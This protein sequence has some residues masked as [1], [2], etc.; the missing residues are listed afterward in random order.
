M[1]TILRRLLTAVAALA[2]ALGGV[3]AWAPPA[4]AQDSSAVAVNTRD[5]SSL[6]RF[7]FDIRRVMNG[8]IDQTN[9]AIAYASCTECQ[10]VAVSYQVVLVGHDADDVQ[11]TNLAVAV[12]EECSS[13]TTLASA[14]QF[15]VGTEG[16][17]RFT[18]DGNQRLAEL[19]R[20]LTE[21]SRSDLAVDELQAELDRIA[22]E[23]RDVL[24]NE[25][26]TAGPPPGVEE[27]RATD[28]VRPEEAPS[29]EGDEGGTEAAQQ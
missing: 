28:T 11:P 17:V 29:P 1:T 15:V 24:A 13:C 18:A 27:Q 20:R 19:R 26:E 25:V 2:L 3:T 10:T 23:L 14:Y 6:F 22:T 5:G 16:P 8:A 12:N 7:A 4:R 9:V 21:L